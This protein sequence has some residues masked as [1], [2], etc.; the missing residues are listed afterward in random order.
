MYVTIHKRNGMPISISLSKGRI[1]SARP[2]GLYI[3]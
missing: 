2:L 1:D 3:Y